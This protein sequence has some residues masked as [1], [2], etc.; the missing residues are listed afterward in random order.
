MKPMTAKEF[1][2]LSSRDFE[3]GAVK[4]AIYVALK[5]R[6]KPIED[7]PSCTKCKLL[8]ELYERTPK[9]SRDYWLMTELFVLLH[10]SDICE[11]TKR[12]KKGG[13]HV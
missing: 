5:E 8:Y 7:K 4:E 13:T 1:L 12:D 2:T 9:S 6:E 3:N 10:G 11:F